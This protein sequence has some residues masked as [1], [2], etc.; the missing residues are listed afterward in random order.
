[1]AAQREPDLLHRVA[2]SGIA[3]SAAWKEAAPSISV[4]KSR[5]SFDVMCE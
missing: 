3:S 4:S 5:S 2:S 1:M